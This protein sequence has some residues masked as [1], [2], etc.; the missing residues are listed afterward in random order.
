M[1]APDDGKDVSLQ[2]NKDWLAITQAM[3][4][5]FTLQRH[6]VRMPTRR[7]ARLLASLKQARNDIDKRVATEGMHI[8]DIRHMQPFVRTAP[9]QAEYEQN[10]PH[11]YRM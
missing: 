8:L 10:Q 3:H 4:K 1:R 6:Q 5:Y 9:T 11:P 2:F 7:D